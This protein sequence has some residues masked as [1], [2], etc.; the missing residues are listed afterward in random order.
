MVKMLIAFV[1]LFVIF[2]VGI[3]LFRKFTNKEKWAVIKTVSYSAMVAL[4]VIL[5][6]VALVILF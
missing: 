2:F 3:D 6:L 4:L 1:S 5:V